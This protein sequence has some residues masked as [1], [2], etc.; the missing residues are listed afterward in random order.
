MRTSIFFVLVMYACASPGDKHQ[1]PAAYVDPFIGTGGKIGLGHGNTFPGACYP[2]GMIQLSPDNGGQGWEYCSGY[3]YQDSFIV[4]FTHTHL[5]GTGVGDLADI[6][7]MPTSKD[8]NDKYFV[9][10]DDFIGE[11]CEESG[12]DPNGFL[13]K[14]GLPA[15]FTKNYLLKY[16]SGFSH[17]KE[18]ASP[19][20]YYVKLLDDNIDVE[21][22]SSKFVGMHR[23][24]FNDKPKNQ[25][26]VL[27][28]GF[29]INRDRPVDT[30]IQKRLP[31][32][33]TG[34]RFSDGWADVHRVFFA[35]QFSRPVEDLQFFNADDHPEG[36]SAMGERLACALIFDGTQDDILLVKVAISS[37]S[38]DGA[39]ANLETAVPFGWDFDK[40]HQ[41]TRDKWNNELGKISITSK[42]EA[43]KTT[44]YTSLYHSYL[45]PFR[46][47]DVD[48]DYKNY[49]HVNEKAEG[50]IHYTVL[51]LWDTFRA[52]KPL[53]AIM[54]PEL[55][56]N[57]IQSMLSQYKQTGSL[58]YWEL[59]GNEGGSMIG[60]HAV[61]VI[62]D[63]I[64]KN[65]G[66]YDLEL[67]YDAMVAASETDRKGLSY[68]R[69]F[70]FVPADKDDHGTVSKTLEYAFDDWCIA[71]VAKR[72]GKEDEYDKYFTRSQNYKNVYDPEY[73]LMR[74]KKSDGNWDPDFHPRFAQYGNVH[75][76]E[77]NTWQYSFFVP[78]DMDGLIELMGGRK[79]FEMMLDSLFEQTTDLLGKDT[80][81]VTGQIGQYAHGNEPSH[82]VAYL[83]DFIGKPW[84]TQYYTNKII[85]SLYFNAPNGLCGNE[86]CGQMSAWYVFS[87]IGFYPVNPVDNKYYIGSPQFEKVDMYLP[88]GNVFTVR[89][90][91]VSEENIYIKSM[92]LNGK[93]I[94]RA[95]ITYDDI[96]KGGVLKFEMSPKYAHKLFAD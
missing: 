73:K 57:I 80:E 91:N 2:F 20:Y 33:V 54:Q 6:S 77:G 37:V 17:D 35:M 52:L 59:V 56:A 48:G 14:D 12:F 93:L 65:I 44:F 8:I 94:N 50:Y 3:H 13:N 11:F 63:A 60:Y 55:Y 41:A 5:S 21:L 40:M 45:T 31:D 29:N 34:Y 96:E 86:D 64:F 74:G 42:D 66:K 89:A 67:A 47:S 61:P 87:S 85:D 88:N 22:T 7:L 69:E 18:K 10:E 25:H 58:P 43:K 72:L 23:Y 26:L 15:A 62:A 82:H 75:T 19:G 95:Y 39:L 1:D 90:E 49:K 83:Y 4:G 53:L 9:Q 16:R 68:Y 28:L 30:Y 32:L 71:Q 79:D 36:N 24:K 70:H 84:K 76:V 46:F 27:N 51:S 78:Q 38:E 92:K 81:D